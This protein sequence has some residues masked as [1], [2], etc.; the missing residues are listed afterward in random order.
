[1]VIID[2][3]LGMSFYT[4]VSFVVG[5]GVSF[6]VLWYTNHT[7][8]KI[9]ME[10]EMVLAST[11]TLNNGVLKQLTLIKRLHKNVFLGVITLVVLTTSILCVYKGL[12]MAYV[13]SVPLMVAMLYNLF[14]LSVF[15]KYKDFA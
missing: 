15:D 10:V 3:L 13:S 6:S 4:A 2:A 5:L 12:N 7:V 1:M 8:Q 9:V 14:I 11:E